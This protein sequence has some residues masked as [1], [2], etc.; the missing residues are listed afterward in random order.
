M[1]CGAAVSWVSQMQKVVA[2]S[3]TESA[4]IALS[5]VAQDV[6]FLGNVLE[7][8][9][10]SLCSVCVEMFGDNDGTS[11]EV[12]N[13]TSTGRTGHIDVRHHFLRY[14]IGRKEIRVTLVKSGDQHAHVLTKYL[15]VSGRFSKTP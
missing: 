1:F 7:F 4:Y 5:S 9:Q 2:L 11:E 14:F 6:I 15:S 13:A 8:I 12:R 3:S 10:S